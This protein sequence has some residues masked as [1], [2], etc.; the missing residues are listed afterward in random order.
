METYIQNLMMKVQ[1]LI[2]L[3]WLQKEQLKTN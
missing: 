1:A 2:K 3:G